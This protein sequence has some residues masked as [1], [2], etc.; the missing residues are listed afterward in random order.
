MIAGTIHGRHT[1]HII[2]ALLLQI[3]QSSSSPKQVHGPASRR[4]SLGVAGGFKHPW[5]FVF[6]LNT[7]IVPVRC[8][9]DDCPKSNGFLPSNR[10]VY[11]VGGFNP[12]EKY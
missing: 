6:V 11:L 4:E 7:D 1:R 5:V 12:F 9:N 10:H 2:A 3:V 8:H